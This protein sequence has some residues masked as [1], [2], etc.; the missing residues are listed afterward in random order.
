MKVFQTRIP[1]W[2]TRICGFTVSHVTKTQ[3]LAAHIR[4]VI[5]DQGRSVNSVATSTG[6][7]ST[8]PRKLRGFHSFTVDE[9]DLVATELGTT[10]SSL[11]EAAWGI[12]A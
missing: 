12:A 7:G 6:M 3:T 1:G 10:A 9:L 11:M 8:L 4:Q 2:Q 5:A